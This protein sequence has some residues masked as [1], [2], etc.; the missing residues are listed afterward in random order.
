VFVYLLQSHA[1]NL[2][3]RSPAFFIARRFG[4]TGRSS[5]W[6]ELILLSSGSRAH[7]GGPTLQQPAARRRP[8]KICRYLDRIRLP[9][10]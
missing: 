1:R 5:S 7:N 9:S 8:S 2:L 4:D 6:T 10:A 3:E